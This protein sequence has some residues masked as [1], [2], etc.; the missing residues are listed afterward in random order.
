VYRSITGVVQGA[1]AWTVSAYQRAIVLDPQNPSYRVALGGVLY[2]YKQYDD[3]LRLFEQ[4]ISLKSDWPNALY[5]YAWAA[6]QKEEY[7]I[8]ANAMQS[9]VAL[10]NPKK[11]AA[12]YKKASADLEEFKKKVPAETQTP[13]ATTDTTQ[14]KESL[15]LPPTTAP[16]VEPKI[17]LPKTASP[18]AK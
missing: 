17:N 3:A 16:Q 5:N 10:L 8:A 13:E 18:E 14:K 15:S 9:C 11:D 6:Y 1:D 2:G 7:A 4:A 12:D